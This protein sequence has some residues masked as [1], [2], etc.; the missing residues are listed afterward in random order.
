VVHLVTTGLPVLIRSLHDE[1]H[2]KCFDGG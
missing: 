1:R 2:K